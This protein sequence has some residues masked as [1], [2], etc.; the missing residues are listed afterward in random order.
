MLIELREYTVQPG[1]RDEWV[2][3]MEEEII[4]FQIQ[5]GIAVLGSFICE[6]NDGIYV[7]MRRFESEEDRVKKYAAVYE[8]DHWKNNLLPKVVGLV[9]REKHRI[10]RLIPTTL[11][12]IH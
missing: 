5:N 9:D 1:K 2:K 8:S 11:S 7:W 6:D 3:M 12:P 10:T 4:P